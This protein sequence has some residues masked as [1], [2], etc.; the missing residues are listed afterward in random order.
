MHATLSRRYNNFV[1]L[2]R[3]ILISILAAG[4]ACGAVAD[5]AQLTLSKMPRYDRYSRLQSQLGGSVDRGVD[6]I[7]WS[8]DGKQFSYLRGGKSYV[9]DVAT[10]TETEGKLP[11]SGAGR[12]RGNRRDRGRPDRG[13]QFTTVISEDGKLKAVSR[14]RNVY[15]SNADGTNEIAVT[16]DGDEAKRVKYGVASWVYG[17]EL[18]VREAMWFSPDAKKLAYYRFDEADVKDYF[19][20]YAQLDTQDTLNTEPYPKV[21]QPNPKVQLFIYDID[22]KTSTKVGS[23]FG[24]K[25]L[26]HYIYNVRWSPDGSELYFNRMRRK[27]DT[28][29]WC[30]AN[31]DSGACRIVLSEKRTDGWSNQIPEV[32]F[33][34]DGKRFVWWSDRTGWGNY[35]L[36][37]TTGAQLAALSNLD[38]SEVERIVNIDETA[39]VLYYTARDGDN[40][41]LLQLHKVGLD[42]K[43]DTRLT[44]P[45][46]SHTAYL[47][48]T[49]DRF[50]DVEE[51]AEDPPQTVLRDVNGKEIK[52]LSKADLKK[53]DEMGLKKQERFTF[54]AADGKT[55]CYGRLSFPSDFDPGKKYPLLI[56]VYGG[57]ESGGGVERFEPPNAL[58]E[59]GFVIASMDGRGTRG[60]G[61]AFMCAVYRKLGIVEIDD[62]AAGVKE[63]VAKRSYLD[64]KR[65]GIQGTSYGGYFSALSILRYPDV[66]AA[67]CASS[68]VTD[69]RLYD[70]IYTERYMGQPTEDDNNKGYIN[71]SCMTYVANLKGRLMLYYG[72]ADNNVHPSNTI[73]LANKLE[74]A[75]KRF[76]MMIGADKGHSQM[77]ASRMWEYFVNYLILDA[78][79]DALGQVW[80]SV[81]ARRKKVG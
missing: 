9:Y 13:R 27:Q 52:Q 21:G 78:S 2:R 5:D 10:L 58:T 62:H 1:R 60:R 12:E 22:T 37:D 32:K 8:D 18:E 38:G 55:T 33:L 77:N 36:Y 15:L 41:Y 63:L 51:T 31:R 43:G 69:F 66:Y 50:V 57:P 74:G 29:Q 68:P 81:K 79:K 20:A 25:E 65:V 30:A 54:T 24:D 53:W 23:E 76:D 67:A 80:P 39:N 59:L 14:D 11:S 6:R 71:G 47:A 44:D 35:Y 61:R 70:S 46:F 75:G 7:T 73:Q 4:I 40:P 48:P 56:F 45:K 72:T 64:G 28:M 16:S 19:I 49:F 26:G 3:V 17:E 42:G 34:K